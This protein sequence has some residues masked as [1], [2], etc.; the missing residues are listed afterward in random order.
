MPS[1]TDEGETPEF[2]IMPGIELE[3]DS[4][5][6]SQGRQPA[7]PQPYRKDAPSL[8]I[9]YINHDAPLSTRQEQMSN[10][11]QHVMPKLAAILLD[12]ARLCRFSSP[13]GCDFLSMV[14]L[15]GL[16]PVTPA[17]RRQGKLELKMKERKGLVRDRVRCFG[18]THNLPKLSRMVSETAS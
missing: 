2:W 10:I 17:L 3:L 6:I 8:V 5:R 11:L 4:L 18:P 12:T 15:T 14:P 1:G 9:R 7:V 16:E 13:M